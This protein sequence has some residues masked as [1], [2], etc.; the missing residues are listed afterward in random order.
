MI[1]QKDFFG[2]SFDIQP[3]ELGDLQTHFELISERIID[4]KKQMRHMKSC[5]EE[6][7]AFKIGNDAFVYY[8]P[9]TP[10]VAELRAI[11]GSRSLIPLIIGVFTKVDTAT[12]CMRQEPDVGTH[13]PYWEQ[14]YR[15]I[16]TKASLEARG[17]NYPL[18]CRVDYLLEK[19][20]KLNR[21]PE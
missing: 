1:I 20:Q 16:F 18:V 19:W 21:C 9:E 6:G 11:Y 10:Y 12:F 5:I 15:S 4:K 14:D 3:C 8:E 17:S 2:N 13:E 7:T